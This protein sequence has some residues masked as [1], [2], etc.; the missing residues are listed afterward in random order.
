MDENQV[1]AAFAG[2]AKMTVDFEFYLKTYKDG[3]AV[4]SAL[5]CL[6][7]SLDKEQ[8]KELGS[9]SLGYESMFWIKAAEEALSKVSHL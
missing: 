3:L 6:L 4:K 2:G 9:V 5:E 1:K 8:K 7:R